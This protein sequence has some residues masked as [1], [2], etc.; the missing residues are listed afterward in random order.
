M[1]VFCDGFAQ[2]TRRHVRTAEGLV[3]CTELPSQ[4]VAAP[5]QAGKDPR[6]ASARWRRRRPE[7]KRVSPP[8][9]GL[10]AGVHPRP[11]PSLPQSLGTVTVCLI[12]GKFRY[13]HLILQTENSFQFGTCFLLE[14]KTF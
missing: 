12:V 3:Q 11:M 13:A 2:E 1:P 9:G 7:P 8:V 5:A 14:A 10:A 6:P 4:A